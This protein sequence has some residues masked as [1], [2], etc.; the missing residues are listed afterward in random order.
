MGAKMD[1]LWNDLDKALGGSVRTTTIADV[2]LP[3]R[4]EL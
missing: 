4:D 2:P 3:G 1:G